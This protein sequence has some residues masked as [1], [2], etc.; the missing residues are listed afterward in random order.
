MIRARGYDW[1]QWRRSTT[2]PSGRSP[3]RSVATAQRAVSRSSSWTWPARTW[4]WRSWRSWPRCAA[5]AARATW[6][7][8]RRAVTPGRSRA[9]G[10]GGRASSGRSCHRWAWRSLRM[11]GRVRSSAGR[12][13]GGSACNNFTRALLTPSI[14]CRYS[15]AMPDQST[16]DHRSPVRLPRR[17]LAAPSITCP[18]RPNRRRGRRMDRPLRWTS[19]RRASVR[20]RSGRT[21]RLLRRRSPMRRSGRWPSDGPRAH[22]RVRRRLA[23]LQ[24]ALRLGWR[25]H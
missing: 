18:S 23:G 9:S 16:A 21:H 11:A 5:P 20:I 3:S 4:Y 10:A 19:R 25:R 13:R 14:A 15:G 7:R 1:R 8:A 17:L 12:W 2:G 22:H 24:R 6:R